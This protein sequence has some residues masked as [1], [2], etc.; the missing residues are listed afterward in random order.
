MTL[1]MCLLKHLH[2]PGISQQY[3]AKK[4][5]HISLDVTKTCVDSMFKVNTTGNR[6]HRELRRITEHGVHF[7]RM[8]ANCLI[9]SCGIS[10]I[11]LSHRII[12]SADGLYTVYRFIVSFMRPIFC[13]FWLRSANDLQSQHFVV[14]LTVACES[15]E[16][17][18]KHVVST[19][20]HTLNKC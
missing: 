3:M 6:V 20:L 10:K 19:A 8:C 2:K 17:T 16:Q 4:M 1:N 9:L 15:C 12:H 5:Y 7:R 11:A 14:N 18:V 13:Y